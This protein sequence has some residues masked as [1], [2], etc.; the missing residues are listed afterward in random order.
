MDGKQHIFVFFGMIASGKSYL[1]SRWAG[2]HGYS[3]YNSDVVRKE[4]AGLSAETSQKEEVD[5]GI[6]TAEFSRKT[7]DELIRLAKADLADGR[8]EGVVLDGSYQ[9]R[10]ERDLVRNKLGDFEPFFIYC[11]CTETV[12]K[13][14]MELRAKDPKAVSDGRWEIY[15]KQ[16]ERFE[17]PDE[18]ATD[19]LVRIDTDRSLDELLSRL[20]QAANKSISS[21][22]Y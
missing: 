22:E 13:E 21:E 8:Y 20:D 16:K 3:Y 5:Q 2:Q 12:L 1:A 17:L 18:L 10:R 6:Y 19:Q 9:S 7:Y 14:R 4:L 11:F 15:L